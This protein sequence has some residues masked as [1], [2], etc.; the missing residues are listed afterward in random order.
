[1]SNGNIGLFKGTP[2]GVS[3]RHFVKDFEL[4]LV[5]HGFYDNDALAARLFKTRMDGAAEA[6]YASLPADVKASWEKLESAFLEHFDK[7]AA[8]GGAKQTR[9][10]R[11]NEHLKPTLD[12]LRKPEEWDAWLQRLYELAS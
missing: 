12:L 6:W 9:F 8:F 11:Y 1:M 7:D 10:Q 5:S 3:A 2:N 4:Y